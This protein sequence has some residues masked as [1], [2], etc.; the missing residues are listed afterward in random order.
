[1][2]EEDRDHKESIRSRY[3]ATTP[4]YERRYSETQRNKHPILLDMLRPRPGERILDWGCG[5]GTAIPFL[6]LHSPRYI[7]LDFST[8]MLSL[9]KDRFPGRDLVLADCERMPFQPAVFDALLGATVIQN[10]PSKHR[11]L[12]EIARVL[13][14]GGRAVISYPKKTETK[15]PGVEEMKLAV[16]ENRTCDEDTAVLLRK[17]DR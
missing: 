8:G 16:I 3:N 12:S 6:D 1:M 15:I 9:L 11:A 14:P 13:K 5:T 7:G 10:A 2:T 17:T 4:H